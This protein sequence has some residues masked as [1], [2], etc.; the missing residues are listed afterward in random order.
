MASSGSGM[1]MAVPGVLEAM[2]GTST[3]GAA[4]SVKMT[5]GAFMHLRRSGAAE[6]EDCDS[7]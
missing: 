3:R 4:G 1:T 6:M 7:R 5:C 2:V